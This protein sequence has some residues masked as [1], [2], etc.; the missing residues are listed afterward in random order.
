MVYYFDSKG[1][2]RVKVML[3]NF[4]K[5]NIINNGYKRKITI[6]NVFINPSHII[7]I[8]DY[9]G[10]NDFLLSEAQNQLSEKT[11]SLITIN[12]VTGTEEVIA[13]GSSRDIMEK[14][15]QSP[16]KGLLNG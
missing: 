3:V 7:S 14:L 4:K 15:N 5:L 2:E 16:S 12:N 9:A 10:I 13:L 1:F 6:E 8:R 11:F